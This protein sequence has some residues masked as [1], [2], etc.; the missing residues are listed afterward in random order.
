MGNV[1]DNDLRGLAVLDPPPGGLT[2]L[3]RA[4]AGK[5]PP[6]RDAAS[7]PWVTCGLLVVAILLSNRHTATVVES[8][9]VT[10][11][12][13]GLRSDEWTRLPGPAAEVGVYLARPVE[14]EKGDLMEV[15]FG[16]R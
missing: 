2:R 4:M 11:V 16:Q 5:D 3:R 10:E 9:I 1:M 8:R 13:S 7:L 15:P 6:L 14:N 12:M